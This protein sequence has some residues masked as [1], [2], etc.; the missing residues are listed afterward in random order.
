MTLN[1]EGAAREWSQQLPRE[2]ARRLADAL[3]EGPEK[4]RALRAEAVLPESSAAVRDAEQLAA[5]GDGPFTAGLLT[6]R[7]D[8]AEEQ[9]QVTPV[10]TGPHS[11]ARY[12]RLTLAVLA[13]LIDEARQEIL[14]VSYAT[15]PSADIRSALTA[16]VGRGVEITLLLER[17]VDN[18]QFHGNAEPFPGLS[19]RRLFWPAT[20]R[21]NGASMH[22]KLLVVDRRLALV[23]SANLTGYGLERNLECGLLIRGGVVPTLLAEHVLSADGLEAL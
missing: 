10:W 9:P 11:H 14:L 4:V 20:A 3:R 21:P 5:R 23:G 1:A 13:D 19:A 8:V 22:A 17:A 6:A 15:L 18:P 12:G 2:F 7:L 16:S